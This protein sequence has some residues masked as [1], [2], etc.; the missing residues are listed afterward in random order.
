MLGIAVLLQKQQKKAEGFS[1]F[2]EKQA[3]KQ[4]NYHADLLQAI[5]GNHQLTMVRHDIV[6]RRGVDLLKETQAFIVNENNHHWY[7]IRKIGD[8]YFN[9]DSLKTA[10]VVVEGDVHQQMQELQNK[11][12]C[13]VFCVLVNP[14]DVDGGQ[15]GDVYPDISGVAP[16]TTE[17]NYTVRHGIT[18]KRGTFHEL[19]KFQS[20][21]TS[22]ERAP[23]CD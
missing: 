10:P 11:T 6:Q 2:L 1:G 18:G 17:D 15:E 22:E 9:L 14:E 21:K 16:I 23:H 19:A 5:L 7:A 20:E 3:D 8:R 12:A 13:S 4:G